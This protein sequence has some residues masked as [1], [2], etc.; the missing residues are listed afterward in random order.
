MLS[1]PDPTQDS[2]FSG[3]NS[4]SNRYPIA[5]RPINA[6]PEYRHEKYN[7]ASDFEKIRHT[8]TGT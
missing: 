6:I 5:K 3:T 1:I 8:K 2:Y 4:V 7:N